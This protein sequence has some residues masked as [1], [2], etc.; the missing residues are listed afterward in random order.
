MTQNQIVHHLLALYGTGADIPALQ[1][2]FKVNKSYQVRLRKPQSPALEELRADYDAAAARYLGKGTAF[3]TWLAFFQ[4]EMD[5]VGGDWQAV[6]QKYLFADTETA[7]DLQGRLFGGLLHP[8][9][10]LLYGIEWS[11]PAIVASALAQTAVHK[12]EIREVMEEVDSRVAAAGAVTN[13]DGGDYRMPPLTTLLEE[14][15]T[16]SQHEKLRD[17]VRWEDDIKIR[18]GVLARAKDKALQLMTRVRVRE[19]ELEERTVEM[20]HAAAYVATSTALRPPH[21][22]KLDFFLM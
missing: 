14:V 22:P 1:R 4:G 18:D 13:G 15:S 6:L 20:L 5:D 2:A 9:I 17:S 21:V 11:Q 10:Q 8:I 16:G 7:R 3:P 19:D 12:N